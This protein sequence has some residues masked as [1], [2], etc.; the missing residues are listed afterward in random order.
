MTT[1]ISQYQLSRNIHCDFLIANLGTGNGF[2]A[3]L[4]YGAVLQEGNFL[5]TTA[6]NSGTTCTGSVSDGTT[7]FVSAVDITA[8]GAHAFGSVPKYYPTGGTLT[9]SGAQTGTAATAGE[10]IVY[11]RYLVV[12]VSDETYG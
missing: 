5:V 1:P 2:T 9:I 7:T 4:P 8:T 11:A 12:G 6:F 3:L 10:A